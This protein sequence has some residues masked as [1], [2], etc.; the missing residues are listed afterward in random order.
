MPITR[1]WQRDIDHAESRP[2][3]LER[4]LTH[5]RE[6]LSTIR[7]MCAAAGVATTNLSAMECVRILAREHAARAAMN[8]V[9]HRELTMYV[10]EP[11]VGVQ[12]P[13]EAG[14]RYYANAE[15]A[16]RA[17]LHLDAA[18]AAKQPSKGA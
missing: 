12:S 4:E 5:A 17:R 11:V 18:V 13:F 7:R 15:D 16:R 3:R 2:A 8:T 10:S 9:L 6:H 14:G 1:D